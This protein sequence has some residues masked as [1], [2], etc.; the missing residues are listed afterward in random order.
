MLRVV[1]K[2]ATRGG[3]ATT[4]GMTSAGACRCEI[5]TV[6]S[7]FPHMI[8]MG[9]LDIWFPKPM[10]IHPGVRLPVPVR[11]SRA[12][13]SSNSNVTAKQRTLH[14]RPVHNGGD[15]HILLQYQ[16]RSSARSNMLLPSC[17]WSPQSHR[18]LKIPGILVK[19]GPEHVDPERRTASPEEAETRARSEK[20]GNKRR[21]MGGGVFREQDRVV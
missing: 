16:S 14:R 12:A 6:P 15:T 18:V 19:Q 9:V 13:V 8:I 20:S 7:E 3:L 10:P 21:A 1:D 4:V 2:V 17:I 11:V 5:V